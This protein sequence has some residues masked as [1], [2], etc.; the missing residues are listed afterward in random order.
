MLPDPGT[1]LLLST[2]TGLGSLN[3]PPSLSGLDCLE[4]EL[5]IPWLPSKDESILL[6]S[7]TTNS[8]GF[9]GKAK[10]L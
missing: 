2:G 8:V 6:F 9:F 7:V 3:N 1:F 4:S 10:P 5:V